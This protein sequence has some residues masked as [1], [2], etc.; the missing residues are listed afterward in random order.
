[1]NVIQKPIESSCFE[2]C[3]GG[4]LA[5][6]IPIQSQ[7]ESTEKLLGLQWLLDLASHLVSSC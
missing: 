1:M 3:S 4:I 2:L 6:A 5:R 7:S